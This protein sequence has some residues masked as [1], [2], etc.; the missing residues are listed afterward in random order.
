MSNAETSLEVKQAVE[1]ALR[2][3]SEDGLQAGD[4]KLA[5]ELFDRLMADRPP[6]NRDVMWVEAPWGMVCVFRGRE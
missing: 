2:R 4:F 5:P 1:S 6:G 3:L